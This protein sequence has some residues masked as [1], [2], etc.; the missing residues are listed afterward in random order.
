MAILAIFDN[1]YKLYLT[2]TNDVYILPSVLS[3]YINTQLFCDLPATAVYVQYVYSVLRVHFK[4]GL[5]LVKIHLCHSRGFN[6][7]N[8][9]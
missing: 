1:F 3:Y 8:L 7:K 2:I 6:S 5:L 9:V 4:V